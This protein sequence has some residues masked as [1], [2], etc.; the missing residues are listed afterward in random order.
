[1]GPAHRAVRRRHLTLTPFII[2]HSSFIATATSTATA[3]ATATAIVTTTV[4]IATAIAILRQVFLPAAVLSAVT[5][6]VH[7]FNNIFVRFGGFENM[8]MVMY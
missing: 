3:T 1:V 4:T 6:E 7:F 2:H 8:V 5:T